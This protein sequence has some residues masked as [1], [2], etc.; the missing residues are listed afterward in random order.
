MHPDGEEI[1][2]SENGEPGSVSRET[3]MESVRELAACAL[4]AQ[5]WSPGIRHK[6]S[7]ALAGG[8]IRAGWD[9]NRIEPL[10]EAICFA[11]HDEELSDRLECVRTTQELLD[12]DR[13][14]TGWPEFSKY[15]GSDVVSI[16]RKWLCINTP[17]TEI[18]SYATA[19]DTEWGT[20]LTQVANA[21]RFA[22]HHKH[23]LAYCGDSKSWLVWKDGRWTR[24]NSEHVL[25]LGE[26]SARSMFADIA[27]VQ[28]SERRRKLVSWANRSC[29]RSTIQDVITLAKPKLPVS[30]SD[31]DRYPFLLNCKNGTINLKTAELLAHSSNDWITKQLDIEFDRKADCPRFIQ[32]IDEITGHNRDLAE[33]IQRSL[34]YSL[35]GD[36]SE[37]CFFVA[38]GE[39]A[40]GKSTLLV[41]F[42]DLLDGYALD[43]P[44][45]SF[46]KKRSAGGASP[47][48]VRLRGA[49]FVT[50][51]EAESK[52]TLAE[53]LIKK[54]T[55]GDT[56]AE[57]G[58]YSDYVEFKPIAKFW[59]ATNRKPKISGSEE[60]MWR[61]I[62]LI[63]FNVVV[64]P[65]KRD[66]YLSE[67]L[68][69]EAPGV[70]N[71]AIRGCLDWQSGRL[72]PPAIVREATRQYRDENDD[73][74][75][76]VEE[77]IVTSES[78]RVSNRDMFAAYEQWARDNGAENLSQRDLTPRLKRAGLEQ[79]P[80]R[81]KGRF[82]KDCFLSANAMYGESEA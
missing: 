74:R 81:S 29:S 47:D 58:L 37:Q 48:L 10:I 39:G 28:D 19:S 52:H 51:S 82:W 60:A 33:F 46:E 1:A 5:R 6:A 14:A 36:N 76:F 72:C 11:A 22:E 62:H 59:L 38:W 66:P 44:I 67:K 31:M 77:R 8:L 78:Q 2:F 13:P 69:A 54:L 64:P 41:L 21:E 63:P 75:Q 3:L 73:I 55:G 49:R 40:N 32:F 4:I 68:R 65:E 71:W 23:E 45:S 27:S 80:G 70:L 61:R 17:R 42:H 26:Q 53:S 15:V 18:S 20:L 56:L 79:E 57:R 43:T 50:V 9:H 34:G 24:D 35:T 16:L 12:H 7:L 25:A 30:I